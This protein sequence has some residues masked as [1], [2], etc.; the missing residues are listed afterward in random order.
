MIN[1]L[2][3]DFLQ[4]LRGFYYVAKS[5]SVRKAAELMHRNPSTISY[6]LHALENE[7]GVILFDRYNKTMRLT[8]EG[9][10]LLEWAVVTFDALKNMFA[11]VTSEGKNLHGPLKMAATLPIVSLAVKPI[12]QFIRD[13]PAVKLTIQRKLSGD[14]RKDVDEAEVDFGILPVIKQASRDEL[15]VV[16]RARPF[17]I[18]HKDLSASI[19]PVPE[20]KDLEKLS[21]VAF[22]SQFPQY[23]L[24]NYAIMTGMGDFIFKNAVIRAN[25][26]YILLRLVEENIGVAIMDELCFMGSCFGGNHDDLRKIALDHIFPNCIYGILTRRNKYLSPQA[27]A[28]IQVLKDHFLSIARLRENWASSTSTHE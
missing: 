13:F 17:L 9:E 25:N 18:F 7:L 14:V 11:S 20:L 2:N 28:L 1:E 10:T 12:T 22:E 15:E 8:H 4:W 27:R 6:Q 21:F 24:G 19:P 16:T 23:D 3:G 26:Y 5:G